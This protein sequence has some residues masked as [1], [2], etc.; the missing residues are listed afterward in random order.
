MVLRRVFSKF[1]FFLL[2]LFS[3]S[4][5]NAQYDNKST[6]ELKEQAAKNF[7]S[8]NFQDALS[9]YRDLLKRYPKDG[10]FSYYCGRSL[11]GMNKDLPS[12]IQ[13]LEF[14]SSKAGVPNDVFFQL[15]EAYT[16]NYQFPQ[17]Q[18][19]FSQYASVASKSEMKELIPARRAEMSANATRLT[20][21]YN[22]VDVLATSLFTF[23]DSNYI[24]QVH[25]PGG[26]LSLKP[27]EL[28][29]SADGIKDIKNLMFLPHDPAKGDILFY[30]ACGKNKKK[31]SD[32]YMV[33]VVNSKKYS[34]PQ[35]VDAVNTDYD[36][37]LPYYDPIGK[38]LYY[39]SM[40]NNSMG[41]FDLFKAHYD[42]ERN[43]WTAP[44]DLGFPV[45]SPSN[46]YLMIPGTDLGIIML[47]TDRQGLDSLSTAY[48]LRIHE[49]RKQMAVADPVEL[50][51]IGKFGGIEAIPEM[52]D[53]SSQDILAA[54]KTEKPSPTI[55]P[56]G[57]KPK[58]GEEAVGTPMDYNKFLK[59]A[60]DQQA[61]ADSFAKLAREARIAVKDI[62]NADE[63]WAI[64]KNIIS[65]ENQSKEYQNKADANYVLVN[66]KMGGR[67][68]PKKIP[69]AI[70]K[71]T[72]INDITVYKFKQTTEPEKKE[73]PATT[74]VKKAPEVVG[75]PG[76]VIK[77]DK[78]TENELSR[79]V[80]LN[81]SPYSQKNPFPE[82]LHL[83]KGAYY[84]IQLA[85][86]GKEPDWNTFG[87][88]SPV[89]FE[90]VQGKALKKY[91]AGKFSDYESAKSSLEI[92]RKK[93]FPDAFIVGW[94]DGQK[95]TVDKVME[96]EKK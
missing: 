33:K 92:V 56:A 60:L 13:Y 95:M 68:E 35:P 67:P 87:G 21:S 8:G 65:W 72:I 50:K 9:Q 3:F 61:K 42:V 82:D 83:P 20:K 53:M 44:V 12:A 23:S 7:E 96:L 37:I 85:V 30:A 57:K 40:G 59:D 69:E 1:S 91:Y 43:S 17:A 88:L 38:D 34:D 22:S 77:S 71:D 4:Q 66:Q 47:I 31:G 27:A 84:K 6:L 36:E 48:V 29:P 24:S 28:L 78:K 39:A 76:E 73:A 14:A 93:G 94:Y 64:Q 75:E 46:D 86:L 51:R 2:I 63:R 62:P 74:E 81:A 32:I 80:V 70:E 89:S 10:I 90:Q 41:G 18:K 19:A 49:P 5:I 79:F 54:E 26:I 16:K 11:M 45:N 58:P 15:G 52:I 55:N 25:A